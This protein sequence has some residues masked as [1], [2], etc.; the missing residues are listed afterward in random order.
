MK[1]TKLK[2]LMDFQKFE[3]EPLLESAIQRARSYVDAPPDKVKVLSMNDLSKLNAAGVL[4]RTARKKTGKKND[5]V[6]A[7]LEEH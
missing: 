6:M 7:G 5:S 4:N 3:R 2:Q 1:D